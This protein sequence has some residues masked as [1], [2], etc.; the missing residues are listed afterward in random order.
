MPKTA[1]EQTAAVESIESIEHVDSKTTEVPVSKK[2]KFIAFLKKW[3][4]ALLIVNLALIFLV[5]M[6]M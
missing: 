5:M 3:W 4:W 2:Q 1:H 6:L